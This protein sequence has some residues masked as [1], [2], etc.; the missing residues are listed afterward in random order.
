M[1]FAAAPLVCRR[2]LPA[3]RSPLA[4]AALVFAAA[5]A[6]GLSLSALRNGPSAWSA[7]FDTGPG[8]SFEAKNE[9]LPALP[10]AGRRCTTC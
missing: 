10:A 5:V 3:P 4:F 6:L 1:L 7:I 2:L 9:Y 8:G